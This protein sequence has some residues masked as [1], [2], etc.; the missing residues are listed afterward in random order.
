MIRYIQ[1]YHGV[2]YKILF[3]I[4]PKDSMVDAAVFATVTQQFG[5]RLNKSLRKSDIMM[6]T[7]SNQFF[8][9][10]PELDDKYVN[11]V[12]DRLKNEWNKIELSGV[13]ELSY[14]TEIISPDEN[15]EDRRSR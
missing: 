1:S 4:N 11:S 3:T 9:L 10:L 14:A 5:E 13:A 7:N 12:V 15:A 8:L 2:A 6:Q